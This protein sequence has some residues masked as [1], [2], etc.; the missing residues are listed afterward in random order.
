MSYQEVLG[1]KTIAISISESPEMPVLGLGDEHL[2][3]AMAEMARHLLAL[4][5]RLIYGG[6]LRQ[7]GFSN[8][9]FELVARHPRDA[10]EDDNRTGVT[11]YL[12]WPVH[13]QQPVAELEEKMVEVE[14]SAEV[15]CLRVDGSR[16]SIE[17]RR[18]LP[19][20]APTEQ[21]WAD[22]LTS[23][24]M[25]MMLGSDARVVVGGRVEDYKGRRQKLSA[26]PDLSGTV[27]PLCLIPNS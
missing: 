11:N 9:L 16:L 27:L 18:G 19:S 1:Q 8:L 2:Q 23:M 26:T 6:D 25:T 21:E 22:G 14:D 10:D 20:Q 15:I 13:I 3:D 24:R 12:A 4:G 5:A 17:D 7:H